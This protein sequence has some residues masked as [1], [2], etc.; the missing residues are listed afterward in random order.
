MV[1]TGLY[2]SSRPLRL[3]NNGKPGDEGR[4]KRPNWNYKGEE[5]I[6]TNSRHY[7]KHLP[8][9]LDGNEQRLVVKGGEKEKKE[10][11]TVTKEVEVAQVGDEIKEPEIKESAKDI[12]LLLNLCSPNMEYNDWLN[13]SSFFK[14]KCGHLFPLDDGRAV[15]DEWNSGFT[16]ARKKTA[17]KEWDD[18]HDAAVLC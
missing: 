18:L 5:I 16:G 10:K 14:A 12:R 7:W 6:K 1:D 15:W 8:N 17:D 4:F 13:V 9:Y 3:L 2:I 11:K